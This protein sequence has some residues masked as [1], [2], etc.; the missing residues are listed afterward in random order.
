MLSKGRK[1]EK[2]TVTVPFEL[3][4]MSLSSSFWDS[5]ESASLPFPWFPISQAMVH[6]DGK[7][8]LHEERRVRYSSPAFSLWVRVHGWWQ[9]T[10]ISSSELRYATA[11][12]QLHAVAKDVFQDLPGRSCLLTCLMSGRFEELLDRL[13]LEWRAARQASAGEN[14]FLAWWARKTLCTPRRKNCGY[15]YDADKDLDVLAIFFV[16]RAGPEGCGWLSAACLRTKPKVNRL[17][18]STVSLL[19]YS[20]VCSTIAGWKSSPRSCLRQKKNWLATQWSELSNF[21]DDRCVQE[22][23]KKRNYRIR[24]GGG[25]MGRAGVWVCQVYVT[26][27]TR[28]VFEILNF[29]FGNLSFV[30]RSRY[31]IL[32]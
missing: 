27:I 14:V 4:Q 30:F 7:W 32:Y 5:S 31:S 28:K 24:R 23:T 26:R 11:P 29:V 21:M 1:D 12:C 3:S 22:T 13:L 10:V 16:V 20:A 8:E 9:Y 6:C 18:I 19:D 17:A 2:V 25:G 15:L